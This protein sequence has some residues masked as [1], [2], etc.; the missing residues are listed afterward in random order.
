MKIFSSVFFGH[1]LIHPLAMADADDYYQKQIFV[2]LVD[3]SIRPDTVRVSSLQLAIQFFAVKG[4]LP[5]DKQR[6]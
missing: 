1:Y 3:Y 6:S 4:I 2:N 5:N